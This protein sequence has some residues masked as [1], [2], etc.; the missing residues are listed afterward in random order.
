[1]TTMALLLI[2]V[3]VMVLK[4]LLVVSSNHDISILDVDLFYQASTSVR[5]AL[6][7]SYF[8]GSM[9]TEEDKINDFD[10]RLVVAVWIRMIRNQISTNGN[11]SSFKLPLH[12]GDMV[13]TEGYEV[14]AE[15]IISD[16]LK[17]TNHSDHVG[18]V[19]GPID[20]LLSLLERKAVG[21]NYVSN[22][23]PIPKHVVLLGICSNGAAMKLKTAKTNR[24][25][26]KY[27]VGPGTENGTEIHNEIKIDD[28]ISLI[29]ELVSLRSILKN[30]T[31]NYTDLNCINPLERQTFTT[32]VTQGD[33]KFDL[34]SIFMAHEDQA[35]S[36]EF[37]RNAGNENHPKFFYE[38]LV[39]ESKLGGHY[40]WRFFQKLDYSE[41]ERKAILHRLTRAWLRFANS[42]GIKTWLAHGTL[43]GWYWNGM[44]LPWDQDVDVQVTATSLLYIAKFYNQS[45]LVDLSEDNQPLNI[46][47]GKYLLE[48]SLSFAYRK[49]G[50]GENNIDARLI[51]VSTGMYVDITGLAITDGCNDVEFDDNDEFNQVL[52]E[53]F[54]E[55]K[56]SLTIAIDEL[57]RDW[58]IARD[59]HFQKQ[60]LVNCRDNHFYRVDEISPLRRT[61]FEGVMAFVP[62]AFD[63][64]LTREYPKGLWKLQFADHTFRPMRR[65]WTPTRVCKHDEL[66]DSCQDKL[67]L[68]E[69]RYTEHLTWIHKQQ[70]QNRFKD[71]PQET[72]LLSIRVD[73]WILKRYRKVCNSLA[74]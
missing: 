33:F 25:I 55:K 56:R 61:L 65:L 72:D 1:M 44:N 4:P 12:W 73:P 51:D 46:G 36:A 42:V 21:T 48:V 13:D 15:D 18:Y 45:L 9:S 34:T 8:P 50:N 52:D 29:D 22:S 19:G 71:P 66:G 26:E 67:F 7:K 54:L 74:V 11:L 41:Y 63:R 70:K 69:F 24:T 23:A 53:H 37:Y 58:T 2:A 16:L 30:S 3:A 17:K 6:E 10:P 60:D 43:M 27:A 62:H 57:K 39:E 31:I 28:G 40:D 59:R 64:I 49:Q 35:F 47:I 32:H 5:E 68:L 20:Q 14:D 38:A